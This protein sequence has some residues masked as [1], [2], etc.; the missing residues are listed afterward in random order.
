MTKPWHLLCAGILLTGLYACATQPGDSPPTATSPP[1]TAPPAQPP[2]QAVRSAELPCATVETGPPQT[3]RYAADSLYQPAAVLPTEA[4]LACLEALAGWLKGGH[5]ERWQANVSGEDGYGFAPQ[6][7]A[8]KRRELLV[9]FFS[10]RGIAA[11]DW[12][13]QAGGQSGVQLEL[14]RATGLP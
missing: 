10:R 2:P 6:A 12:D 13:W 14:R 3:I 7:L 9:R 8:E 1:R 4:G 11:Q 5:N